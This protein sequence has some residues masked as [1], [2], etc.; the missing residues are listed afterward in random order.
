[1]PATPTRRAV[2]HG[3]AFGSV[4]ATCFGGNW[5]GFRGPHH[6]GVSTDGKPPVHFGSD[7]HLLWKTA[8]PPGHSSPV[9]TGESVFVTAA[10]DQQL[11]TICLDRQTGKV[12]WESAVA[13]DAMEKTHRSNSR[14]TSTP[15]TDGKS[16]FAYFSSFGLLAYDLDGRELWRKPLPMPKVSRNQGTG[17]SP[18]LAGGKLVLYVL[19]GQDSHVL[20]LNPADGSEFWRT[21]IPNTNNAYSTPITWREGSRTLIGVSVDQRFA[22]FDLADGKPAWWVTG[23][24]YEACATPVVA[25]DRVVISTAGVQGEAAN[26]TPPPEFEE[27]VKLYGRGG[28]EFV[29]FDEIPNDVLFT[30]RKGSDGAGNTTLKQALKFSKVKDG[31]K[32]DRETWRR[33]R[34][35]AI[36]FA[37]GEVAR[38]VLAVVRTGGSGDVTG[39][40]VLWRDT[41]G[42][43]EVPS[44]VVWQDR[45]YLIRNG[46]ILSCREL[47]TGRV[48]YEERI[49]SPGGYYSSPLAVEGRLYLASDRGN[50]AVVKMG[51]KPE[52]LAQNKLGAPVFASPA[53]VDRALYFRSSGHLWAF[54]E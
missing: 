25:G 6:D 22:A 47:E 5:P 50:I 54:G 42:I 7:K 35:E 46:S 1:M 24:G 15:V 21:P 3:L 2:L 14:A 13:V 4:V 31:D 34:G 17:T 12:R 48:I 10:R 8:V 33:I 43:P 53:V 19:L 36:E 51:G 52:V 18:M 41:K 40:H 23:L 20:A 37:T 38:A 16:L 29:H 45:L 9:I 39:S 11:V 30:D 26:M 49:S 44:P 32:L 27:A 28:T